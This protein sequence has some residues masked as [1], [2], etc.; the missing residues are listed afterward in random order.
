MGRFNSSNKLSCNN[1]LNMVYAIQNT[2]NINHDVWAE[3]MGAKKQFW[4]SNADPRDFPCILPEVAESWIRSRNY[5]VNPYTEQVGYALKPRE[6]ESLKK[7]KALLIRTTQS[8]LN[9]FSPLLAASKYSMSL[10]DENGIILLTGGDRNEVQSWK[11]MRITPGTVLSE[12]IAGTTAHG[13]SIYNGVPV[14]IIGPLNYC[15]FFQDN[16]SSSAPIFDEN[17]ELA[18]T[19]VVVQMVAKDLNQ[20]QI[21]SLG[22]VASMAY[23][24]EKSLKIEKQNLSLYIANATLETTLSVIDE[25]FITLDAKGYLS[26]V[27]KEGARAFGASIAELTGK[28]YT[29][30]MPKSLRQPISEVLRNGHSISNLE[31][32]I[33]P[34][35][36]EQQYLINLEPITDNKDQPELKGLVMRITRKEKIDKMVNH[37]AGAMA[38]YTFDSL[39]G[40]SQPLKKAIKIA[41]NVGQQ[42]NNVLLIGESGTGKELFAQAI[43]NE[44]QPEG[45]FVAINCAALPRNLIES[46]LFGYVGGSFTGA[47]R[48]G[49][50]GKIELAHGGTLF[51]DEI[52]DMPLELQPILLRVL[53]EKKVMRVGGSHY[54]PVNFRI[55]AAT[56]KELYQLVQER[57]FREDLY[58]RLSVFKI[59]IPPLR[60]RGDDI[61][62]LARYFVEVICEKTGRRKTV[63]SPE[64]CERLLNYSWPGNVRQLENAMVYAVNMAS[65]GVIKLNN[66]PDEISSPSAGK[67]FKKIMRLKEIEKMAII[68]AMEQTE[69]NTGDAAKILGVGRT[70]LYRKLKEYGISG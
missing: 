55:I 58:Y 13:L 37:R 23:A 26:Q 12:E 46:E 17:D 59:N 32:G 40:N 10:T 61:L 52:G 63:L 54:I 66:L 14:Q 53:E 33:S 44:Y 25:G 65:N 50:P 5:G 20:V 43:H 39:A 15:V 16:I 48:Q 21:H 41:K 49:R 69:H 42:S 56:N 35:K 6:Y 68:E 18:G 60:D 30:L 45:P 19:L 64:V 3:A 67:K 8:F 57:T 62:T 28:H 51:L 22:W 7:D 29:E 2:Q 34:G 4:E 36:N 11:D 24:I 27:N 38:T 31:A 47:D 9:N 70:T 1:E